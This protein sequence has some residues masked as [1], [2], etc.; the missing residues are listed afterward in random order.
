MILPYINNDRWIYNFMIKFTDWLEA[1]GPRHEIEY[2]WSHRGRG[3]DPSYDVAFRIAFD[4]E[5]HDPGGPYE[6]P[7]WPGPI[8]EEIRPIR[9][10]VYHP[11]GRESHYEERDIPPQLGQAI[12]REFEKEY[13]KGGRLANDVHGKMKQYFSNRD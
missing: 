9:I 1:F 7:T 8:E 12:T 4:Y 6:P 3:D 10:P 2:T 5:G 11:D 13:S